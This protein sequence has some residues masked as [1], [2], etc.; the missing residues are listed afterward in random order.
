MEKR[1][2]VQ[3][4]HMVCTL[5]EDDGV[6]PNNGYLTMLVYKGALL[7]QPEDESSVIEKLFESNQ[8][9]NSWKNGIFDYHHY[10]SNT[11]EV[12]GVFSGTA[13]LQIGGPQGLRVEV[14]RGDVIILPAG[15]AHM[16]LKKSDDFV[17]IGA[18]PEGKIQDMNYGKE[19]ERPAADT[20]IANVQM[21]HTDPVYGKNGPLIEN[22]K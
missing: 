22:W 12:L 19:G 7:L 2:L 14:V 9:S 21:P 15:V 16:C 1:E 10:H 18:Y 17:V 13:E 3:K 20:N 11:H 5:L 6:F 8:W 4:A